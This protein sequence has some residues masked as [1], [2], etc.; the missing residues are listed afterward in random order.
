M[1]FNSFN[2]IE[3]CKL[4]MNLSIRWLASI[5]RR[6]SAA[7]GG[8]RSAIEGIAFPKK[9]WFPILHPHSSCKTLEK[10]RSPRREKGA[11]HPDGLAISWKRTRQ[12]LSPQGYVELD[13]DPFAVSVED[14]K[15]PLGELA[16]ELLS[17]RGV[18]HTAA[19]I[20]HGVS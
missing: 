13:P 18:Y 3:P 1:R 12:S 7:W 6:K 11:I 5:F 15:N 9:L 10:E 2:P 19:V 14:I 20:I 17:S 16:V 8:L 4:I